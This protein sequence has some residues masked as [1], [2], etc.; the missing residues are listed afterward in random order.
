MNGCAIVTLNPPAGFEAELEQI[1]GWAAQTL[2]ETGA[3]SRVWA[4]S[5]F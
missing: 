1:F 4:L 5:P 3:L 2:G